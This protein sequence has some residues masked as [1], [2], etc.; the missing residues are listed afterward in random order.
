MLTYRMLDVGLWAPRMSGISAF[1]LLM[2]FFFL[3][4]QAAINT[5]TG[6][7]GVTVAKDIV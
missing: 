2:L 5:N 4:N 1:P 6:I 7:K 3:I